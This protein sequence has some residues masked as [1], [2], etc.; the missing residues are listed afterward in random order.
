MGGTGRRAK[1]ASDVCGKAFTC[2]AQMNRHNP[3]QIISQKQGGDH[4]EACHRRSPF[5]L[6]ESSAFAK[7]AAQPPEKPGDVEQCWQ[8]EQ[9][10]EGPAA[11]YEHC[12]YS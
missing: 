9:A 2:P 5:Y 7:V 6:A 1:M 8:M 10:E 4:K 11:Y 12:E 3:R